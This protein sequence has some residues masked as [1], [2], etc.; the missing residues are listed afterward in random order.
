MMKISS[1]LQI[2]QFPIAVLDYYGLLNLFVYWSLLSSLERI[3]I[4]YF[5]WRSG[6]PLALLS[7]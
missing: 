6:G 1:G 4:G 5:K 2:G 7:Y 3:P